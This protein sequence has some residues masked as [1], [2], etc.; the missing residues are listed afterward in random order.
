MCVG[1]WVQL[2][3][4]TDPEPDPDPVQLVKHTDP[5]PDPDPQHCF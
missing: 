2:V 4:H 3:I 5:E 1:A